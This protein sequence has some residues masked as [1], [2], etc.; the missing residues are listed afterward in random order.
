[1][2]WPWIMTRRERGEAALPVAPVGPAPVRDSPGR[3]DGASVGRVEQR[4]MAEALATESASFLIGTY[5][6]TLASHGLAV[7][8]WAWT[9]LLAHGTEEDLRRQA[10]ALERGL[11]HMRAWLAARGYLAAELVDR[12]DRG[13]SLATLQ[14]EVLVPFELRLITKARTQPRSALSVTQWVVE[15]RTALAA[16]DS[17]PARGSSPS[18]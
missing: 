1:M 2:R 12:M 5:A 6:E 8:A 3:G 16:H 9:N 18:A 15:V 13:A 11:L 10:H 4:R 17:I 7:P 14:R